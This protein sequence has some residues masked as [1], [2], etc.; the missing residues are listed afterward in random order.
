VPI[1][2]Y[3]QSHSTRINGDRCGLPGRR[4]P[5]HGT[6]NNT[7]AIP[8]WHTN[9]GECFWAIKSGEGVRTASTGT[10]RLSPERRRPRRVIPFGSRPPPRPGVLLRLVRVKY[11]VS[12]EDWEGGRWRSLPCGEDGDDHRPGF[13]R[14]TSG[15][16]LSACA[17]TDF[18]FCN[19]GKN[20]H[21]L[22]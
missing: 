9:E 14:G 4:P 11:C 6:P 12:L 21:R 19:G 2:A 8:H 1:D 7:S 5:V 20:R 16:G 15:L 3:S 18:L 13:T 10:T 22:Q 17:S